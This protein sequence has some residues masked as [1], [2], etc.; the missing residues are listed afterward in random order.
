MDPAGRQLQQRLDL[1]RSGQLGVAQPIP[2]TV[3]PV[4]ENQEVGEAGEAA[5]FHIEWSSPRGL[6]M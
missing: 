3:R 1:D 6:T 4:F 5:A 2:L